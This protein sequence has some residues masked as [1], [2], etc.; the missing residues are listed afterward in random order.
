MAFLNGQNLCSTYW[1]RSRKWPEQPG[2]AETERG[3]WR[4]RTQCQVS[5]FFSGT[6]Q[7]GQNR[8]RLITWAGTNRPKWSTF[9]T[10][11]IQQVNTQL[12]T[13]EIFMC[14]DYFTCHWILSLVVQVF[15]GQCL[16]VHSQSFPRF[17]SAKVQ[18]NCRLIEAST[19]AIRCKIGRK[20][21]HK[22]QT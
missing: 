6:V 13:F 8:T 1:T 3:F 5:L 18:A 22:K 14:L 7:T 21:K 11:L 17:Q 10:L 15:H 12:K 20:K 9:R 16:V 19:S 2:M 4:N